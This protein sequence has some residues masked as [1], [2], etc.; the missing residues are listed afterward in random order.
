MDIFAVLTFLPILHKTWFPLYG[1]KHLIGSKHLN[2]CNKVNK[3]LIFYF[4]QCM[5]R[6]GFAF[7]S[8][9]KKKNIISFH[10]MFIK[11]IPCDTDITLNHTRVENNKQRIL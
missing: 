5:R 6:L 8:I 3:Y 2:G 1:G 9:K 10:G 11:N 7:R 4:W